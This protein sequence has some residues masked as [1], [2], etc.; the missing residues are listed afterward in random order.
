[1]NSQTKRHLSGESGAGGTAK[2]CLNSTTSPLTLQVKCECLNPCPACQCTEISASA[3][4]P[5]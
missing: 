5:S 1:M 3:E 2:S 4:V